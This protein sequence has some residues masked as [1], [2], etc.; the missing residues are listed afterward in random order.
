MA[1]MAAIGIA[2]DQVLIEHSGRLVDFQRDEH[3][4]RR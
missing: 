3:P 2:A 1:E 4:Y